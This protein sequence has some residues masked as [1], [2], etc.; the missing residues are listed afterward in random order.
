MGTHA[1]TLS[2]KIFIAHFDVSGD[3]NAHVISQTVDAPDD[4]N[5]G[6][7]YKQRLIGTA[8]MS[9][10][11][12][13]NTDLTDD[14]QDEVIQD[15]IRVA[16]VPLIIT[17]GGY[18]VGDPCEFGLVQFGTYSQKLT[19]G[20]VLKND[21][22]GM[23]A[24]RRWVLGKVLWD[25]DTSITGTANGAEVLIG[26]ASATQKL[27]VAVALYAFV[28]VGSIT[29]RVESD[30]TGFPST[31]VQKTFTALTAIGSEMPAP[32]DGAITDTYYRAAVSAFTPTSAKMIVVAGIR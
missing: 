1:V 14:L 32:V 29:V 3:S 16:N 5:Y 2:P 25:P 27:Y 13:G 8:D 30:T 28:G 20:Q 21:V 15:R 19:H 26:A 17:S 18:A 4:S 22:A 31:T 9:F 24:N 7:T 6:D 12:A 11:I 10:S 23:I